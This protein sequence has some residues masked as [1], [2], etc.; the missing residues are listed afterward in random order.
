MSVHN[1]ASTLEP[2]L[3]SLQL[4]TLPDWELI[5]FDDGSTDDSAQRAAA[6][7]DRRVRVM[8]DGRRLGLALRLNQAVELARGRYLAR[9]DGDDI[10]YPERLQRQVAFLDANPGVD[11]L[12]AGMVVFE[13]EGTPVGLY[14]VRTTHAQI[15]ARPYA[16]FYLA[17]PSWMGRTEWFRKWRYDPAWMKSQDQDLLLRAFA[18]SRY[19][20]LA[21]TLMGYRQPAIS[22]SKTMYSRYYFARAVVRR[23]RQDRRYARGLLAVAEQMAKSAYDTFAIGTGMSRRL[24]SHRARP[25]PAGEA[26]RWHEVWE[27]CQE[28]RGA[29]Q[30]SMHT[31]AD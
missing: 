23:A 2:A 26:Q 7:E 25:L 10:A 19:A 14:P 30:D 9:M 20:A 6:I 29:S 15:C 18:S 21:E 4:Q 16:G 17:H 8:R 31:C 24:L 13:G 27:A 28:R 22:L 5:L 3:R 12:G 1:S 11:L